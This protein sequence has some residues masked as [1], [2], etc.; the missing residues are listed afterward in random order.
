MAQWS[1]GRM[2]GD[3]SMIL[4]ACVFVGSSPFHRSHNRSV[5]DL[6]RLMDKAEIARAAVTPLAGAFYQNAQEA[7]EEVHPEIAKHADRLLLVA[8]ANPAYPGWENDLTRSRDDLGAV[9]I[10]LFPGYHGYTVDAPEVSALADR[11][12]EIGLPVFVQIRLWDERHHPPVFMVPAVPVAGVV[13]LALAH[14][15]SRFVLSMGRGGEI[16]N[17]LKQASNVFADIAGVQGPTNCVRKLIAEVGSDRL[18]FGTELIL[19]YALPA[20]YKVDYAGLSDE[21]RTRLYA[22]NLASVLSIPA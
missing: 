11:A 2:P 12:A 17:A 3:D 4:D 10:R 13:E 21:D 5:G 19:Q 18:L 1:D 6:L 7:N 14:P 9:A 16:T 20:R 22:G 8:A 15:E